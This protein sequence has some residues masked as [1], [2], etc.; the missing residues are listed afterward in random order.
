M[1]IYLA[2]LPACHC[3]ALRHEQ[4]EELTLRMMAS[5]QE[6]R[7]KMPAYGIHLLENPHFLSFFVADSVPGGIIFGRGGLENDGQVVQNLSIFGL[8]SGRI[9]GVGGSGDVPAAT[10]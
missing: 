10:I 4:K 2:S 9:A 3:T 1:G 7:N 6:T 5:R 8:L